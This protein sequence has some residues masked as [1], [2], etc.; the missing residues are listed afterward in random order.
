MLGGLDLDKAHVWRRHCLADCLGIGSIILLPLDIGLYISGRHQ[1]HAVPQLLEL[2]P[3]MVGSSTGF[4]SHKAP[5]RFAKNAS[6]LLRV[7]RRRITT[8]PTAYTMYL[9]N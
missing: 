9:K 1:P 5:R 2:S 4:H 7:R 8:V 3:P 6:S